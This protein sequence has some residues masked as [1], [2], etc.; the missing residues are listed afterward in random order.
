VGLTG[1]AALHLRHPNTPAHLPALSV[2]A[3]F[4]KMVGLALEA[5]EI[6]AAEGISVEVINLR[7][8]RPLDRETIIRSVHK[9]NRLVTVEEGWPQHGIGAE[10]AAT[11]FGECGARHAPATGRGRGAH[12][13][14]KRLTSGPPC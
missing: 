13:M 2:A 12:V 7:S 8:I 14:C 11:I 10:I 6:L 4:S 1:R 5:A 9:T 3:A